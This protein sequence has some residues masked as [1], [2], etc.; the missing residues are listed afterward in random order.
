[1]YVCIYVH[2]N[3]TS[4][5]KGSYFKFVCI[6]IV[7]AHY[8]C[9][10]LPFLCMQV[11]YNYITVFSNDINSVYHYIISPMFCSAMFSL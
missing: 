1:M 4:K 3:N 5:I 10:L 11:Q 6:M 8:T 9:M 7:H 2:S